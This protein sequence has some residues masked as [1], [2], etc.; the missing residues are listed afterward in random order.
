MSMSLVALSAHATAADIFAP[1]RL[2]THHHHRLL[3][4]KP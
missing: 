2:Q 3:H 4:Q 1:G